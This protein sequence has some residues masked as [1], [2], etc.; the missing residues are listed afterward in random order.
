M[1]AT[2]N[3]YTVGG[4]LPPDAPSYVVR[5]ADRELYE[6][7]KAGEFC[8]VFNSRQTGKSSLRARAMQR[9]KEEGISC[10]DIDLTGINSKEMTSEQWYRGIIQKLVSRLDLKVNRR[11]WLQEHDD[12]SPVQ[13]FTEFIK[14]VLLANTSKNIVIFVDEIDGLLKFNFKDDFFAVI[15]ACYNQR[16]DAPEYNCLTFALLGVAKPSDLI[17]DKNR[18]PFNIGKAIELPGFQLHEANRLEQGLIGKVDDPQAVLR[19]VI[20]WTG[21]QPFLT[22]KLCKL[23]RE[24]TKSIPQGSEPGLVETLVEVRV[25]KNWESQDDPEHLRTIRDRLLS[26]EQRARLLLSLY[27]QILQQR[28]IA[29]DGS[30]EQLELQLSGLVVKRNGSIKAYNLIYEAVFNPDWVESALAR[31]RPYSEEI[32]AWL[33][34][35]RQ[36]EGWLLRGKKLQEAKDW[37]KKNKKLPE[38]YRKFL[39]ESARFEMKIALDYFYRKN[40]W[41]ASDCQD[42]KLLLRERNLQYTLE[43]AD[44]QQQ[45]LKDDDSKLLIDS[46][47]WDLS[48]V[49]M[50]SDREKELFSDVLQEFRIQLE[51]IASQ[52]Y[53]VILQVKS[54]TNFQPLLSRKLCQLIASESKKSQIATGDEAEQ[55]RLLVQAHLTENSQDPEVAE[56]LKKIG[57]RLIENQSSDRFWLLQ[58]YRQILQQ[59]EVKAE[60]SPEQLELLDSGL[61]IQTNRSLK[62]ANR[63]YESVFD[64]SWIERASEP[65]R[66]YTKKLVAWLDSNSQDKD[67]LLRGEELRDSLAWADRQTSL[68]EEEHNFLIKSLIWE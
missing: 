30:P 38:D 27:Q 56:H 20:K 58:K 51:E 34:S 11:A 64:Q 42:K 6:G 41:F 17:E 46:I 59:Q 9:L 19:E 39:Q 54:W 32:I 33:L 18:T 44:G 40:E 60:D 1:S 28:E 53:A 16:A 21:G 43:W 55:V 45:V 12:L 22:Q 14:Y 3:I 63:I 65:L 25:I 24:T 37:E 2:A 62:V 57:D 15:R 52:P 5:K 10:V 66:P 68:K 23:I 47:V 36:D 49:E 48:G 35:G 7:L 61:V 8:Y 4:T 67:Q 50:I 26:N 29:A 13:Q 31:V